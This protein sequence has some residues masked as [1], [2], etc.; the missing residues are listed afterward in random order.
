MSVPSHIPATGVDLQE[1]ARAVRGAT[2][3]TPE[4]FRAIVANACPR[5]QALARS[6]HTGRLERLIAA[7]AW[8]DAVFELVALETPR[9]GLRRLVREAGLWHCS[10]SR[11]P[12]LPIELDDMAEA[13]HEDPALAVLAALV[14][15]LALSRPE[16]RA[17]A[18]LPPAFQ[19]HESPG[20][21]LC[22]DNFS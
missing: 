3:L 15:A 14:E 2:R 13:V 11:Q 10:L 7:Q 9:W 18:F 5:A 12:A 21:H 17:D 4:L 8:T 22:C 16:G 6:G 19:P 1:L 20:I